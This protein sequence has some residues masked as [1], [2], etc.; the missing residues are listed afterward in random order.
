MR[1][2]RFNMFIILTFI[3]FCFNNKEIFAGYLEMNN[4]E[5]YI[6]INEDSSMNVTEIWD[7]DIDETNTLYK[8]FNKDSSKYTAIKDVLVTNMQT[9]QVLNQI[10]EYMYHV[11]EN[12]FFGLDNNE[13][14]FEIAWGVG[15]DNSSDTRKYKIEYKIEN[16][17]TI[18]NDCAELYW[19]IIGN[20]FAIPIEN[21]TGKILL[22]LGNIS[23]EDIKV[24]GHTESLNGIINITDNN[25]IEFKLENIP[26]N[27]MIEIRTAFPKELVKTS[28]REY[29][30]NALE[31]IINE[32]TKWADEA[33]QRRAVE[34]AT[35]NIIAIC[36]TGGCL[37]A[38]IIQLGALLK[39]R[40]NLKSKLKPIIDV[41]YFRELPRQDATPAQAQAI[42]AKCT[43]NVYL[44]LGPV[45]SAT[46]MDLNLKKFIL[47]RVEKNE[48]NKETITIIVN[49]S[50]PE[51][52]LT[53]D[54]QL[55]YDF[56]NNAVT[57]KENKEITIKE[58]QKYIESNST[59]I[60][61]LNSNMNNTIQEFL[62]SSDYINKEDVSKNNSLIINFI[63]AIIITFLMLLG[64]MIMYDLAIP[65]IFLGILIGYAVYNVGYCILNVIT[66][67]KL[68]LYTQKG[69]D[70]LD[71]W[72]GLKKYMEDFS[73]MKD[74][75]LPSI[76]LWEKYLVYATAFGIADKVIKQL[77]L[78]YPE[79]TRDDYF[80]TRTSSV[81]YIA[82]HT[83][84]NRS[85]SSA[86]SNSITMATSSGSGN[87]GGFSGGGGFGGG[88]GGGGGR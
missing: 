83:D 68:N 52:K 22:P 58:L 71:K 4:L 19:Q 18:Y 16:A 63:L 81:M 2:L 37:V 38:S 30:S 47:F 45:F 53:K 28:A 44:S 80:M 79:L 61:S 42:L 23:K 11:P 36:I 49:K 43:S 82:T 85:F 88:G 33:N 70:E 40:K 65:K 51:E 73:S 3:L 6:Q 75:E 56:I 55:V 24:W 50:V 62:N 8:T 15:L 87:G 10:D 32:E 34:Q 39:I 74:K 9:N 60:Y 13:D 35:N 7:I 20:E 86:V 5:F 25:N 14:K 41:E 31:N 57:R 29:D 1:R 59:K 48:K 26:E 21:V 84:F 12:Y 72:Q 27:N 76:V 66:A 46:L 67:T 77:K 69:V 78:V 54:E 64:F 17:V